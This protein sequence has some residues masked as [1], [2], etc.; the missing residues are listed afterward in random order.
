MS[1]FWRDRQEALIRQCIVYA[2]V[3]ALSGISRL[4]HSLQKQILIEKG[5]CRI[6]VLL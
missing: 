4:I 3:M 6:E 2:Y 5:Q 1:G